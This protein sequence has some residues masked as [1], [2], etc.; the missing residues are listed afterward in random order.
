VATVPVPQ[1]AP[2]GDPA[3]VRSAVWALRDGRRR[4][5]AS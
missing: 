2:A 5:G 1:P 4:R 3:L